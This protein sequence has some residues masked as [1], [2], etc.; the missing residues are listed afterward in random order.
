MTGCEAA[1]RPARAV[2][3]PGALLHNLSVVRRHAPDSRVM[4]VVKADAYGHGLVPVAR[5]LAPHVDALAVA[6]AG[7]GR[8]LRQ[9]GIE[10]P[11]VVLHGMNDAGE[12]RCV[13]EHDL[14]PV[15]HS[16]HQLRI[17]SAL[18]QGE[19]MPRRLWIKLDTGMHRL[20]LG[21]ADLPALDAWLAEC[22]ERPE[23]VWMTHFACADDAGDDTTRQQWQRFC[24]LLE[25]REGPRSAA[26]SAAIMAWP[27]THADWVRPGIMLYGGSPL[28]GREGPELDLKPVMRFEAP[29]LAVREVRAGE[30][31]GYGLAWH[32]DR[33]TRIGIVAAGYADGYPR[34]APSGTPAGLRGHRLALAGRVS[35][36]ML[37]IDLG[38][39]E[40]VPGEWVELWGETVPVD[41]V[42]A[43]AGTIGYEL[44]CATAGRTR[45]VWQ[46]A[47]SAPDT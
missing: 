37:A 4:A 26:N 40:A 2:I 18:Q 19:R 22:S 3:D 8:V 39:V 16:L 5:W 30:G 15:I 47:V 13:L 10:G 23:V 1:I 33:D 6:T 46:E 31:I 41:T 7:E 29:L 11:V 21:S 25:G 20:G 14:E 43:V 32:A 24:T 27:E 44:L 45:H 12:W 9:A 38:Q 42:A 34:H 28:A 35:M 36:D 17:L